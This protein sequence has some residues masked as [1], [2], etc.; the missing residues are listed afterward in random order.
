MPLV[1]VLLAVHDD[2]NYLPLAVESVL[3]QTVADLEL[4][5]V[6]DAST[7]DTAP[8]LAAIADPRLVVLRNDEQLGLAASLNRG[9]DHARGRYVARLDAD[10]VAMPKR[11]E[12]QLARIQREP[13][14]AIVG[15]AV[16]DLDADGRPGRLHR[17][18][19]GA[20]AVRWHAL[21][22]AP[23]FHPT[24]L[25]DRE[26]L[27]SHGLR[28]DPAFLESEDYDL[29]TRLLAFADGDNLADPL[30]SKRIHPGQATLRRGELQ[31]SFQEGVA[32]REI[33]RLLPDPTEAK[34][35]WRFGTEGEA[36]PDA[37][38]ALLDR[39][40][41]RHG[42]DAGVRERAGRR[43]ARAGR[44]A[45]ALRLSPTLPARIAMER[46]RRSVRGRASRRRTADWIEALHVPSRAVRVAVVSPEPTPYRSPL[47]D[48]IAVRPEVDLTVIYAARTVAGRTWSVE[49]R[50]R[51]VFLRGVAVPGARRVLHHD[52]PVTPRIMRALREARPDVVVVSGWSTFASQ[53]AIA[54]CRARSVP[55]LMLVESHNLGRRS[56]WRGAVKGAVVPRLLGGASGVLAV[57]RLARDSVVA[58]G[59]PPD[60]VGV[61]ANTIDVAVWEERAARLA[62]KRRKL[63]AAFAFGDDDVVVLSVARLAREKGLD[64]L[65]RAVGAAHDPRLAIVV[66]GTG[67]Q[68]SAL[69]G[70]AEEL[71]VRLLLTG[72]LPEEQVAKAYVAADVFALLSTREP[73]GVVVNEAASSGLPLV[74]SDQVGAA[75]DLLLDG[76]NGVLVPA[77]DVAAAA[78]PLRRLASDPGLRRA[79]GDRSRELVRG[80]G[81]EQS[82]ENFVAAAREA[83]TEGLDERQKTSYPWT[84]V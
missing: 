47:F 40:E 67:P 24:V 57:G 61:F 80:W 28:Y 26:V 13:S 7:D 15:T 4:V 38:L 20:R 62:R 78:R 41:Q 12:R 22:S 82:I 76:E 9:L 49:P 31:R 79:M 39:F 60:R 65:V 8:V 33:T 69:M 36:P 46:T 52:Y 45:Q 58:R 34:L 27:D 84:K 59:A 66:A 63:R 25:V 3:R 14:V 44:V 1:S 18:A 56:A 42:V 81:Y 6:D 83:V 74:L 72:E 17:L 5:V 37:F 77:D 73:W 54:W 16:L 10:D 29:W 75:H 68:A 71:G 70:L 11:L 23:F 2:A 50:H 64:T 32:L 53:A 43:L 19:G 30:V 35:A 51:S 21:F 55:Y 48:R